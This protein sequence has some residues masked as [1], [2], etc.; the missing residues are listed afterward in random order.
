MTFLTDPD[1]GDDDLAVH[2]MAVRVGALTLAELTAGNPLGDEATHACLSIAA[3]VTIVQDRAE[4]RI[5]PN[6]ALMLVRT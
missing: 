2:A 3:G 6:E 1:P 4:G 5:Q